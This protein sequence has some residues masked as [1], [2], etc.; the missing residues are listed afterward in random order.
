LPSTSTAMPH[1]GNLPVNGTVEY[2]YLAG[3]RVDF[4][5]VKFTRTENTGIKSLLFRVEDRDQPGNENEPDMRVVGEVP[6]LARRLACMGVA[7]IRDSQRRNRSGGSETECALEC[8][9]KAWMSA[10]LRRRTQ[11][12]YTCLRKEKVGGGPSVGINERQ[13]HPK[14]VHSRGGPHRHLLVDGYCPGLYPK[15]VRCEHRRA[16]NTTWIRFG[17]EPPPRFNGRPGNKDRM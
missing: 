2:S 6:E 10:T 15:S 7:S 11:L 1:A 9:R 3:V 5:E 4:Q 13:I 12:P 16:T 17:I 8:E 14:R